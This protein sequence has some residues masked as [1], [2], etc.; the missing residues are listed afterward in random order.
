MYKDIHQLLAIS[1]KE[2]ASDLHLSAGNFPMLRIDGRLQPLNSMCLED[3]WLRSQLMT[4]FS[5]QQKSYFERNHQLDYAMLSE[6]GERFRVNVFLQR[7]GISAVFRHIKSTIPLLASLHAPA[8]LT[9]LCQQE[10]GLILVT[11]ATGSGKSTT[12]AALIQQINQVSRRHI[13]TLEDPI[14]F[15]YH[16]QAGL[17]QQREIGVHV[18]DFNQGLHAA[19]REDPDVIL[20]GELR[21]PATIA[22]ALTAA[23]TGHLVLSSLHTCSAIQSIE[24]IIDVFPAQDKPFIRQQLANNLKAVISQTLL[25]KASGGRIAA[26]EILLNTPAVSNLIREGKTHQLYSVLQTG[27]SVGMQT[28]EQSIEQYRRQGILTES[29]GNLTKSRE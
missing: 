22:L 2:N 13:L 25:V 9:S 27:S 16:N 23:E 17:I 18:A 12:L 11:G 8:V 19:L 24:R 7:Q 29:S 3:N 15:V 6:Q 4:T 1:V 28:L 5:A 10:N 20:L 26:F 21:Q 14:E